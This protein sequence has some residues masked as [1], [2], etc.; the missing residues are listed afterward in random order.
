MTSLAK[1]LFELSQI[2]Q[3]AEDNNKIDLNSLPV[4]TQVDFSTADKIDNYVNFYEA[5][6]NELEHKKKILN[7][8]NNFIKTL[9]NIQNKL[10][11]NVKNLMEANQVQSIKGNKHLIKILNTGGPQT[12]E[13]PAD[14]F[15]QENCVNPKYITELDNFIEKKLVYVIKNK[16]K[17]KEA[18]QKNKISNCSVLPRKKYVKFN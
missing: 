18:L 15:Y 16:E 17:F 2:M 3:Q 6:V 9:E 11:L 1:Q 12:I 10:K 7:N 4:L 5:V 13:K 14:M 8:F